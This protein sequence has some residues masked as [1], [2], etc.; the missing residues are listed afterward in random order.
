MFRNN[1][2]Y[3][4]AC[5]ILSAN[6]KTSNCLPKTGFLSSCY[7]AEMS[8]CTLPHSTAMWSAV[9]PSPVRASTLSP[10]LMSVLTTLTWPSRA[11]VWM[12]RAPN[13]FGIS[14]GTWT[15]QHTFC[16]LILFGSVPHKHPSAEICRSTYLMKS[17]WYLP[18]VRLIFF[19]IVAVL[20]LK[21]NRLCGITLWNYYYGI[22]QLPSALRFRPWNTYKKPHSSLKHTHKA[23][24][25]CTTVH[26]G[27]FFKIEVSTKGK[28]TNCRRQCNLL[29]QMS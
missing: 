11:A 26:F 17:V 20:L 23:H 14:R 7:W 12:L 29:P 8:M 22:L 13:R 25:T 2:T 3:T 6:Q 18:N 21:K 19:K 9:S 1:N 10:F 15:Q 4:R 27:G 5:Q 24:V 16:I 28:S